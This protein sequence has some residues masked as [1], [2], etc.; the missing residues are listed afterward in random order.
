MILIRCNDIIL[1]QGHSAE[2]S[3]IVY[4]VLA[5]TRTLHLFN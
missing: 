4:E 5:E 1:W 2:L 3:L